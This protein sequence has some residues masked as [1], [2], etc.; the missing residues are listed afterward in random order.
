M[1]GLVGVWGEAFLC[2]VVVVAVLLACFNS[3][4]E[5]GFMVDGALADKQQ[6]LT[7]LN[8]YGADLTGAVTPFSY[9]TNAGGDGASVLVVDANDVTSH[10]GARMAAAIGSLNTLGADL[11]LEVGQNIPRVFLGA[12]RFDPGP[13]RVTQAAGHQTID[14]ADMNKL[15]PYYRVD[16]LFGGT[17]LIL[18]EV[19]EGIAGLG[20][21]F[22]PAHTTGIEEENS[23]RSAEGIRGV[24]V[25]GSS[26]ARGMPLVD[27]LSKLQSQSGFVHEITGD[28]TQDDAIWFVNKTNGNYL[29]FTPWDILDPTGDPN[30]TKEGWLQISGTIVGTGALEQRSVKDVQPG[31][32]SIGGEYGIDSFTEFDVQVDSVMFVVPEPSSAVLAGMAFLCVAVYLRRSRWKPD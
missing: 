31:T 11:T 20:A 9:A 8:L 18:H 17:D 2:R 3:R 19:Y 26:M 25:E 10:F 13:P 30:L 6:F 12:F 16:H 14:L 5:A 29:Y 23:N 1:R 21:A 32:S 22:P 27:R 7:Y 28:P 24:R 4:V 15:L